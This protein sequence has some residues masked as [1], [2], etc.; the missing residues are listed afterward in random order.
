MEYVQHI[1]LQ[2]AKVI[3]DCFHIFLLLRLRKTGFNASYYPRN[4]ELECKTNFVKWNN[5]IRVSKIPLTKLI[6]TRVRRIFFYSLRSESKRIWILFASYSLVSVYS[7]TPFIRIIRFIFVQ[8]RIQIFDLMQK[9]H[10][11]AN[12]RIRANIRWR[13]SHTGEF[14]AS[15]YSFRS[16]YS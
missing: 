13:F 8:I 15:K 12:I 2:V 5:R 16:E 7:Q 11:A 14:F 1:S 6:R 3:A 9:I 10:V 4:W